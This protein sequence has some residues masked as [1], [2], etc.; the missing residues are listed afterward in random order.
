MSSKE[1]D[2]LLEDWFQQAET[3][4]KRVA[5]VRQETDTPARDALD[6]QLQLHA[7]LAA[8]GGCI[9]P[10]PHHVCVA[11]VCPYFRRGSM[12]VCLVSGRSHECTESTCDAL[13]DP[14]PL[15]TGTDYCIRQTGFRVCSVTG[16]SYHDP[17]LRLEY[18]QRAHDP[19][20][21]PAHHIDFAREQK[22]HAEE[23]E[24][25]RRDSRRR[26]DIQ[27]ACEEVLHRP[28]EHQWRRAIPRIVDRVFQLMTRTN[29][30]GE[31]YVR[32]HAIAL[33]YILGTGTK[34]FGEW[35]IPPEEGLAAWLI[36][37]EELVNSRGNYKFLARL[38]RSLLNELGAA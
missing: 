6:F 33:V 13:I 36:P 5:P 10:A 28:L 35:V 26:L 2:E 20:F 27:A 29:P 37:S 25:H 38:Q 8:K 3:E 14:P 7:F 19:D 11:A 16:R 18:G 1:L 30:D 15:Q 31:A 9:A 32:V 24:T 22:R 4:S 21:L 12:Y 34:K 23:L 17:E